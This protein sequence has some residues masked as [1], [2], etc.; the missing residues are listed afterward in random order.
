V[1]LNI[2]LIDA[3]SDAHLWAERYDRELTPETIFDLQTELAGQIME[4][5]RTKLTGAEESNAGSQPTGDLEAY[6]QYSMGRAFFVERSEQALDSAARCFELAVERD[7]EYA[8]AWAGLSMA[9]TMSHEYRHTEAESTLERAGFAAQ[10]AL[11][12]DSQLAEAHSANGLLLSASMK[13]LDS[14]AAHTR[15]AELR[16]GFAGAHQWRSWASLLAGDPRTALEAGRRATLLDPLDPEARGDLACAQLGCGDDEEALREAVITLDHHPTYDWPRWVK[17]LAQFHL[18][19]D[20]EARETMSGLTE[21]WAAEWPKTI[22]ALEMVRT[23]DDVGA[24]RVLEDV[25]RG[26]SPLHAGLIHLALGEVET[27]IGVLRGGLPLGWDG[28]L[29][30]RYF[31]LWP[32]AEARSDP[33]WPEL[34]IELDR[35]WG[36]VPEV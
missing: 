17:G 29:Y 15:A 26:G 12:L 6:R 10:R 30:L 18:G 36:A 34:M 5:L 28:A 19:R 9:L 2:Q 4:Q 25:A 32:T 20:D 7:P 13:A 8:L 35:A 23:G 21:A 22:G 1:R 24:R 27:G 33:S 16:P 14:L 11:E 31:R 3:R